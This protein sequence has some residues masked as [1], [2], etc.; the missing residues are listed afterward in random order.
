M[1][2]KLEQ[3]QEDEQYLIC[4]DNILETSSISFF[5]PEVLGKTPKNTF[6]RN[7]ITNFSFQIISRN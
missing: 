4:Y 7:Q 6:S 3:I 1:R 2:I 5:T